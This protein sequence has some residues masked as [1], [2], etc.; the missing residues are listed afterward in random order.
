MRPNRRNRSTA[1]SA[2]R[3]TVTTLPRTR[4][5]R[6]AGRVVALSVTTWATERNPPR[7]EVRVPPLLLP[8]RRR[9]RL[10]PTANVVA[11][12]PGEGR[13]PRRTG[14]PSGRGGAPGHPPR[15]GLQTVAA[16]GR[17]ARLPA[18]T[19][20]DACRV[21]GRRRGGSASVPPCPPDAVA[22]T[23]A[24]PSTSEPPVP[25][26][27]AGAIVVRVA[28]FGQGIGPVPQRRHGAGFGDQAEAK[29]LRSIC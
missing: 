28:R 13:A 29:Q 4:R 8:A 9:L 10:R 17:G 11:P 5:V 1:A 15:P 23:N 7:R 14:A 12:P 26:R 27:Y 22:S 25:R 20:A 18:G 3:T 2:N 6:E 16:R 24:S 19:G 21:R